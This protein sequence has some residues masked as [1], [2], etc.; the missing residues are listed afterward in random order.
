M[1]LKHKQKIHMYFLFSLAIFPMA[2]TIIRLSVNAENPEVWTTRSLW[3][4]L[5]CVVATFVVHAPAFYGMLGFRQRAERARNERALARADQ[6]R[7]DRVEA[8]RATADPGR[9]ERAVP[10]REDLEL[11]NLEERATVSLQRMRR[12]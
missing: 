9:M 12:P 10:P 7:A 5:E 3:G 11:D 2:A 1:R 4:A 6:A 8:Q